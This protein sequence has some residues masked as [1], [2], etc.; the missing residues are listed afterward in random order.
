MI[1]TFRRVLAEYSVDNATDLNG[2]VVDTWN[3]LRS[4]VGIE[5]RRSGYLD[6]FEKSKLYDRSIA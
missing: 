6:I 3:R 4:N 5:L 1:G 2:V